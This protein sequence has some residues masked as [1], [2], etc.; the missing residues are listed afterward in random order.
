[1][2]AVNAAGMVVVTREQ[3]FAYVGPRDI[4]PRPEREYS[5]WETRS[6]TLVGMTTP[7]Y[8]NGWTPEGKAPDVYMLT[9]RA[10]GTLTKA[11]GSE[12]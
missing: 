7:G 4:I 11:N 5:V 3:F 10:Y 1:M 9:P 6:R 2:S 8:A 12:T